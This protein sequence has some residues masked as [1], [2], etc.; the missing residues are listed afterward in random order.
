MNTH[1]ILRHSFEYMFHPWDNAREDL[2]LKKKEVP[3]RVTYTLSVNFA[4]NAS[5]V[6]TSSSNICVKRMKNASSVNVKKFVI[7]STYPFFG[8]YRFPS[9]E[10]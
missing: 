8:V 2:H 3:A 9:P 6:A 1:S 10:F 7:N 4:E 5:S